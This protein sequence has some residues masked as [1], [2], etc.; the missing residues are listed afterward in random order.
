MCWVIDNF[1]NMMNEKYRGM[2]ANYRENTIKSYRTDIKMFVEYLVAGDPTADKEKLI[3]NVTKKDAK[4]YVKTLEEENKPSTI[5]RKISA[6]M[7]FY[8]YIVDVEEL[9][10]R[11]PF[12]K[13]LKISA[14]VVEKYKTA[15]EILTI[16]E[17]R[18]ILK[19]TYK[20]Q[21]GDRNFAFNS[22]RDRALMSIY[23]IN[24]ARGNELLNAK[25]SNI[26]KIKYGYVINIKSDAV[27][28][29]ID[30]RLMVV[31][32]AEKY[33]VEYLSARDIE[34]IES[35]LIFTTINSKKITTGNI[36]NR[37]E[38]YLKSVNIEKNITVH[39]FR[40][41]CTSI[42]KLM[43]INDSLINLILGWKDGSMLR[44]YSTQDIKIYD[45]MKAEACN[46][47]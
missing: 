17:C 31:G 34:G 22:S 26:E 37:I 38:K 14:L 10:N 16:E 19:A 7:K 18:K 35:D 28:N 40:D 47:L 43:R 20:R 4:E 33:F 46:F 11:N 32:E 29:K 2:D 45:D 15:K 8:D 21:H 1:E 23:M 3:L 39:C 42:L 44:L 12:T 36:N 6:L 24:G 25:L 30:K 27:K 41:T 13:E 9:M 5:N